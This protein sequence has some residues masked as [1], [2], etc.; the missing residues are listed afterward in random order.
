MNS[1]GIKK[2]VRVASQGL[3]VGLLALLP[4]LQHVY[5]GEV[6]VNVTADAKAK[7][8]VG[9][10]LF[11]ADGGFPMD[12]S[13]AVQ[14][15]QEP[16]NGKASCIFSGLSTGLYAVAVFQDL[17]GNNVVDRNFFGVPQEPW[18]VSKNVRHRFREP[19]FSE[20]QFKLATGQPMT[21]DLTIKK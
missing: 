11:K 2:I 16:L 17:N 14:M 7:G 15:W 18:A 1:Y 21:L 20:S 12:L 19:N 6:K 9:C 10:A 13:E 4:G 8:R 3:A 5:A